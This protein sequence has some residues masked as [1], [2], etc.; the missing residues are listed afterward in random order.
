MLRAKR[1][2]SLMLLSRSLCTRSLS[3]QLPHSSA[4]KF[5]KDCRFYIANTRECSVFSDSNLVTGVKSYVYA[6]S[7][8]QNDNKC[9]K[10][11]VYF[12]ENNY[13]WLTVPYYFLINNW[14]I[15][16]MYG[17]TASCLIYVLTHVDK[18]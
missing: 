18:Q 7:A 14:A 3:N 11:A 15:V 16:G 13:K 5:C 17:F 6:S 10:D 9:G 2:I 8:R 4:P 12:Q 1:F